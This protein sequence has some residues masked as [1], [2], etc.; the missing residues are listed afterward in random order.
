MPKVNNGG[1]LVLEIK[2]FKPRCIILLN[3]FLNKS[4]DKRPY[5]NLV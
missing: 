1:N 4:K 2:L 3:K 5:Y